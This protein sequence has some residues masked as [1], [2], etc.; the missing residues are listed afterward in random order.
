MPIWTLLGW[1]GS[2]IRALA[3]G[4]ALCSQYP[5]DRPSDQV[6]GAPETNYEAMSLR[7][8]KVLHTFQNRKMARGLALQGLADNSEVSTKYGITC[9]LSG[10]SGIISLMAHTKWV[11]LVQRV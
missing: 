3:T 2:R 5:T 4:S 11:R 1:E 8:G 7:Q 10:L 9:L 6:A